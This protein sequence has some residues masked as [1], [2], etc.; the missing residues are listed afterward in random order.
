MQQRGLGRARSLVVNR[1][2]PQRAQLGC[3]YSRS[4]GF[5]RYR[6]ITISPM[7]KTG[8]CNPGGRRCQQVADWT[9]LRKRGSMAGAMLGILAWLADRRW[10]RMGLRRRLLAMGLARRR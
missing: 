2:S 4:P 1:A 9:F 8:H 3:K 6:R 10:R 7:V 5:P